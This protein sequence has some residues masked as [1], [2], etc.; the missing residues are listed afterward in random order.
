MV[1]SFK[2]FITEQKNIEKYRVL[3]IS[4]EHGSKAPTATRLEDEAKKL[5]M[6]TYVVKMNGTYI[7]YDNDKYT[8][9]QEEDEKGFELD[10]DN[11]VCF[12]R[13]TP[14]RDSY[15]D[16]LSQLEKIGIAMVNSRSCLE[17]AV[18][19]YRTYLRLKDFGLEQPKTVLC[20][21]PELIEKSFENLDTKFP[22]ILKTLRGSKGVGV[23]FVETERSLNSL[24]QTLYKMDTETDLLMQEYIKTD[25]DVRV[26]VLDGKVIATMKRNVVKGDFRSNASQGAEVETIKLTKLEKDQCIHAAKSIGGIFTGVDFIP[27]KN[28][29]TQNP[30]FLEVNSSPGT[31]GIED[32][33]KLNISKILLE[34]FMD[35]SKRYK[36]PT[37]CGYYESVTIEPFGTV[38]AKF[39]TGNSINCVLHADDIKVVGNQVTFKHKDKTYKTKHFGTYTSVTGGGEDER[40]IVKYDMEFAGTLYKSVQ[41]GLD[42]RKRMGTEVLLNRKTMRLLNVIVDPQREFMV[43][44]KLEMEEGEK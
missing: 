14:E 20:P 38:V 41:F 12:M 37:E 6:Q 10:R 35:K 36:V 1:D 39:D 29:E 5:G 30:F 33:T 32:A 8:I 7:K 28:R 42:N 11:T 9:H 4:T 15:L 2:S 44:T 40:Y 19:K 24:I 26:I 31:E 23:L 27:S 16:L 43:T 34:H 21:S 17:I 25:Y 22:I 18:D 13:G 3:V